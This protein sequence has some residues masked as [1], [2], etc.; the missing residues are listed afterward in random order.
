MSSSLFARLVPYSPRQG[1]TTRGHSYK[2]ITFLG[3][4]RPTWY[5]ITPEFALELSEFKQSGS[6]PYAKP[7]FQVFDAETKT[8]VEQMENEKYLAMLGAVGQTVSIPKELQQ[9]MTMAVRGGEASLATPAQTVQPPKGPSLMPMSA[10]EIADHDPGGRA[11]AL[12]PSRMPAR[13]A[14]SAASYTPP[15]PLPPIAS[16]PP[17]GGVISVDEVRPNRP[18]DDEQDG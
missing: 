8:R 9:P 13:E 18:A 2:G 4:E 7:L 15:A 17:P 1:Y 10:A 12:P 5:E 3:G 16:P 6:G 11:A 14:T